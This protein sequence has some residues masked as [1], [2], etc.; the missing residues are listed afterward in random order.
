MKKIQ[1]DFEP[2]VSIIIPVYNGKNYLNEAIES[3]LNQTYSNIEVIVV[4]DGSND[5]GE[6]EKIAL[7]YGKKILYYS[8]E[9]VGVA[10]ALNHGILKM[11]GEYFSWLSH[12]DKY[13]REKIKKQIDL[14]RKLSNRIVVVYSDSIEFSNISSK[15]KLI[16]AK[17]LC[18][19]K[20]F[21]YFLTTNT[22]IHGCSLLIPRK[23]FEK[24]GMFDVNLKYTQDYEMWFRIA[25][26]FEFIHLNEPLVLSRAHS[27][28]GSNIYKSSLKCEEDILISKFISHLTFFDFSNNLKEKNISKYYFKLYEIMLLRG[29]P[30]SQLKALRHIISELRNNRNFYLLFYLKIPLMK[31]QFYYYW[32]KLKEILKKIIFEIQIL[33]YDTFKKKNQKVVQRECKI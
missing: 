23:V 20:S 9:N 6:T 14:L 26:E 17:K 4:N 1:P 19:N 12:D 30:S 31:S 32:V 21:L 25:K 15:T 16:N 8:K 5:S 2:L 7:S 28:Q 11:N 10:S 13:Y 18:N 22:S 27:N 3:A 33:N 29:L 24:V